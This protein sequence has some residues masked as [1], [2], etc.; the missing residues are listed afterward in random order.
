M[1]LIK[2]KRGQK[3]PE[4]TVYIGRPTKWGNPFKIQDGYTQKEAVQLYEEYL[5][6]PLQKDFPDTK[7]RHLLMVYTLK[8][9]NLACWCGEWKPGEPEIDCH[10]VVLMKYANGLIPNTNTWSSGR[11]LP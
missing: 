6:K 7:K 5:E 3:L 2:R 4:G 8:G 10:G 1:K 11:L 9:K